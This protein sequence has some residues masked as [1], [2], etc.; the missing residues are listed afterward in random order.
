MQLQVAGMVAILV[1]IRPLAQN[2]SVPI[3][4]CNDFS[5]T[6]YDWAGATSTKPILC[7]WFHILRCFLIIFYYLLRWNCG[8]RNHMVLC[9]DKVVCDVHHSV[10]GRDSWGDRRSLVTAGLGRAKSFR[11]SE[12][13]S[14]I[15][16]AVGWRY[17]IFL[18]QQCYTK[19]QA[20]TFRM[21]Q[22]AVLLRCIGS[23]ATGLIYSTHASTSLERCSTLEQAQ[24][25]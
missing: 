12:P 10:L 2:W 19:I 7:W 17:K 21:W 14:S 25:I 20:W 8:K 11:V 16:L 1:A 3:E 13:N 15:Y 6:L 18:D 23:F 22:M 4:F 9:S 24:L 5:C